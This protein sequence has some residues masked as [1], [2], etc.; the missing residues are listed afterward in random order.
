MRMGLPKLLTTV[1]GKEFRNNLDKKMTE[2][3]G[4]KRHFTTPY[5]P[6]V[7]TVHIYFI[8]HTPLPTCIGQWLGRKMEPNLEEHDFQV[9]E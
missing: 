5:H 8:N 9:C 1:Q 2:L 3:L 4:I 7:Y 6:Q